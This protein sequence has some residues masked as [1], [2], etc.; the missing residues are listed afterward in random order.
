MTDYYAVY[1]NS[2]DIRLDIPAQQRPTPTN[3][4]PLPSPA[5]PTMAATMTATMVTTPV[6]FALLSLLLG[7]VLS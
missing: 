1:N 6:M 5:T 2:A 3:L 7:P 4:L